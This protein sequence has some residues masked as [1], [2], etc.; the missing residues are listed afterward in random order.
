MGTGHPSI[1]KSEL[2]T[3]LVFLTIREVITVILSACLISP[4]QHCAESMYL[5][6]ANHLEAGVHIIIWRDIDVRIQANVR[7]RIACCCRCLLMIV[8]IR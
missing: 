3:I 2:V 8:L 1:V 6:A 4:G 7:W 5:I